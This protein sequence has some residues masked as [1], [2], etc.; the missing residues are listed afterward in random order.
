MKKILCL[1][2]LFLTLCLGSC[3]SYLD[4][5]PLDQPS[6]ATFWSTES[7]LKLAANALYRSLYFTDR[8]PTVHVPF[9]FLF[10]Y[11]SD[12]SWDRNLNVWQLLGQGMVT[13]TEETLIYGTWQKAYET[14]GHCNRILA[15]MEQAQSVT[16]P[17]IYHRVMGE[18]QFFRAYWYHLLINLYGDVPFTTEPLSVFDAKLPRTDRDQIYAFVLQELDAAAENLPEAY[19]ENDRGRITQGASWALKSRVALYHEDWDIAAEAAEKVMNLG[20]Y[21]LYPDYSDLFTYAGE[22]S[23]EEIFTIQFSRANQLTHQTPVHTRGRLAGGFVTKIPTQALVDSY[24]CNDGLRIDQSPRYDPMRPFENRDPRM[25]A[26]LVLPGSVFLGYQFE[27][28]P[29]SL[30]VWDYNQTPARRVTNQ[31][32]TNP[33]ATFS[34]YQYRK[35]VEADERDFRN[36]S[37][38]NIMLIRYADVL[39]MYAEAKN[40]LNQAD[41]SVY[42]AINA[43]RQRVNMPDVTLGKTQEELRYII[44]QERKVEFAYEGLR[45]FDIRRWHIAEEV[46]PG[47]LYGRPLRAYEASFIPEFD[48]NGTPH[49]DAYAGKLRKFDTRSFNPTKDYVWPIPQKELDINPNMSQNPGY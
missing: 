18:A 17:E 23:A 31:E 20:I 44:R 1:N 28:H 7:E 41:P 40:E 14:I 33:Y 37:E 12:I 39:L 38:L 21:D 11:A 25:Q 26:T 6:D 5:L 34:G 48:E 47:P 2:L 19:S 3:D 9:Q 30:Q 22:N 16:S 10:D 42:N 8:D 27:T 24:L 36:Q 13:S 35:Y 45:Y 29:D 46:M 43:I 4:R 32:V 49:Y 15:Y